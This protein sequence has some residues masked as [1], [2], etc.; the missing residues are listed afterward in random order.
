M[1]VKTFLIRAEK[2]SAKENKKYSCKVL[3]MAI[4]AVAL[5]IAMVMLVNPSTKMISA[6]TTKENVSSSSED[7]SVGAENV[8]GRGMEVAA[9]SDGKLDAAYNSDGEP[10]LEEDA[11]MEFMGWCLE[12]S[13]LTANAVA[14]QTVSEE[15]ELNDDGTYSLTVPVRALLVNGIESMDR[16]ALY[17]VVQKSD[18]EGVNL[19]EVKYETVL[20]ALSGTSSSAKLILPSAVT[21]LII[22][23][24]GDSEVE[25]VTDESSTAEKSSAT[26]KS[27]AERKSESEAESLMDVSKTEEISLEGTLAESKGEEVSTESVSAESKVE[28]M[29]SEEVSDESVIDEIEVESELETLPESEMEMSAHEETQTESPLTGGHDF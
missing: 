18:E 22:D 2:K 13:K 6:D 29:N 17:A 23:K 11:V 9:L 19:V 10:Y 28:K 1:A 3:V 24:K 7:F 5:V 8:V 15:E 20:E 27:S 16:L 25:T 4:M 26:E 12:N 21:L 14:V